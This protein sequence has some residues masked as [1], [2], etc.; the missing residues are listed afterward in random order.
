[1]KLRMHLPK[2][3]IITTS[4]LMASS[5][6]A[7]VRQ[8]PVT[9]TGQNPVK[10]I[11]PQDGGTPGQNALEHVATGLRN[12]IPAFVDS[13]TLWAATHTG[14]APR[15]L[16]R[17]LKLMSSH[18]GLLPQYLIPSVRQGILESA[19]L[20]GLGQLLP[21]G[22][23]EIVEGLVLDNST[24][25][26]AVADE[27]KKKVQQLIPE[28]SALVKPHLDLFLR[29][30]VT[31]IGGS[32][33]SFFLS[34]IID[35]WNAVVGCPFLWT[36]QRPNDS[37]LGYQFLELMRMLAEWQYLFGLE[38]HPNGQISGGLSLDQ[39]S[40]GFMIAPF[41][42][43]VQANQPRYF[44]G[45]YSVYFKKQS[46]VDLARHGVESWNWIAA[47]IRLS[48]QVKLWSSAAYALGRLRPAARRALG[49]TF[50]PSGIFPD[51]T[52]QLALGYLLGMAALLDGP[53]ID[54]D[55]RVIYEVAHF[56]NTPRFEKQ[57]ASLV[58]LARLARSLTMWLEEIRQPTDLK[59][60]SST[61]KQLQDAVPT[62]T[63]ALQLVLQTILQ[64]HVRAH[65]ENN[66]LLFGINSDAK[67]APMGDVAE[68]ISTLAYTEQ[69]ALKSD[70]LH[71]KIAGLMRGFH[72]RFLTDEK[73]LSALFQ[74]IPAP[75]AL[76]TTFALSWCANTTTCQQKNPWTT[77]ISK[78]WHSW[79]QAWDQN[80]PL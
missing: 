28:A 34:D 16:L 48:E 75:D 45:E 55:A 63:R 74:R 36:G 39:A 21:S 42:P 20:G 30:A 64:T 54:I 68:L 79:A 44:S 7:C 4:I 56:A 6:A 12:G 47:P 18:R 46:Y 67:L 31:P 52:H 22:V 66:Q 17:W 40:T 49:T 37:H 19:N 35:R 73:D 60:E 27:I 26:N 43:R 33:P 70:F 29:Q 57:P 72:F 76:W 14:Q 58:S 3:H 65:D 8:N 59:L 5:F 23:G 38:H 11:K 32:P 15:T 71:N 10:P 77:A 61:L 51:E 80:V 41:D 2:I 78:Q 24:I 69:Y 9:N 53:F 1:M 50:G 13:E 62:L 25:E